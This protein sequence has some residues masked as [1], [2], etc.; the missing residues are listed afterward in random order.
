PVSNPTPVVYEVYAAISP[1]QISQGNGILIAVTSASS[2]TFDE[3]NNAPLDSGNL[4]YVGVWARSEDQYA[5]NYSEESDGASPLTLDL[6]EL[7]ELQD[8]L[9]ELNNT[10][11][12]ALQQE[13]SDILPIDETKISD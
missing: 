6:S 2:W 3:Y 7:D 8:Q 5:E 4:Y 9:D 11:L 13:L 12:P 10:T 1:G